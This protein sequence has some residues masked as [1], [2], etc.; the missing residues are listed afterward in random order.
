MMTF[1]QSA[2][3]RR[4]Q[5]S[6]KRFGGGDWNGYQSQSDADLALLGQLKFYTQDAGQLDRLFRRSG[7]DARISGMSGGASRRMVNVR[8]MKP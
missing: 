5:P 6:L 4:T 1:W 3:Q 7:L 8:S 2:R